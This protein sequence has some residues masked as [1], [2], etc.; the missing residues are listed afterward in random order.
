MMYFDTQQIVVLI[1]FSNLHL[2]E[3]GLTVHSIKVERQHCGKK[4]Q[5]SRVDNN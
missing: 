5:H 1:Q 4:I 2:K 3:G